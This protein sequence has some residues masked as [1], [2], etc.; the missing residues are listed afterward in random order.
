M[1]EMNLKIKPLSYNQYLRFNTRGTKYITQKGKDYLESLTYCLNP[2]DNTLR[3]F[4]RELKKDHMVDMEIYYFKKNF[5]TKE[6]KISKTAGDVDN[7]NK[8]LIDEIFSRMG[9]DDYLLG[10]LSCEK[11]ASDEDR[12]LI[13]MT[14][15]NVRKYNQT[16]S[17]TLECYL[18]NLSLKESAIS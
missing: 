11:V 6:D 5:Y 18:E 16:M 3:L 14:S 2:Y 12:V 7:P 8:I 1:L 9:L 10:R 15:Y 13:R 17:D 4:A